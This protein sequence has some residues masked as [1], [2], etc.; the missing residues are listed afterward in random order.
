[1]IYPLYVHLQQGLNSSNFHKALHDVA[2]GWHRWTLWGTMGIQDI[3]QRYRR[4]TLGPFWL[5][6][7]MGIMIASLGFVWGTLF[8]QQMD[9]YLP[10]LCAGF[11]L[12]ALI[13]TLILEGTTCFIAGEGIIKQLTA[14]LSIHVYRILWRNLI[15]FLHNIVILVL[16][17]AWYGKNPGWVAL[18]SLP[19]L[20]L[21]L[22]NGAWVGLLL[23]LLSARF[24]DIP[25][26]VASIVQVMFFLTP[27]MW[28]PDML[29]ER[30]F[31]LDINPFYYALTI[32]RE[33]L[34][35]V[36]PSGQEWLVILAITIAGW[37]VAMLLYTV[38]RWRLA[39][40]L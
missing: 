10:Y 19:A 33:P 14:P 28:K 6:I 21:L 39:Y 36:A 2:H 34:L 24:R 23:G 7:S 25:Q 29:P 31:I 30:Q 32:V 4:S 9:E 11:I 38:Y 37:A 35:G 18:L 17:L 1:M 27:I 8:K 15:I 26:I 12:W 3:K 40:W 5:T 16:V 13:S 20:V 22:L